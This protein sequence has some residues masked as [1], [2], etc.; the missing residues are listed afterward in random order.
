MISDFPPHWS[1]KRLKYVADLQTGFTLGK[2]YS[3]LDTEQRPYLRVANVQDG[4]LDLKTITEIDVPRNQAPRYE[5]QPG[6][7]LMTEGGDF[8]KLGRGYLWAGQIPGC[9]HQNHVFAV[10]PHPELDSSFLANVLISHYAKAYFTRTSQQT[11]NLVL[12]CVN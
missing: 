8:D 1:V 9:F 5:L 6:D 4:Y 7:V 11:T 10:R 3:G 2:D 12:N